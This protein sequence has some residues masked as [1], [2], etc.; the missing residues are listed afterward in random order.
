MSDTEKAAFPFV[1]EYRHCVG[2]LHRFTGEPER[3]NVK[4]LG[5]QRTLLD[6]EQGSRGRE[7]R[8]GFGARHE[9]LIGRI[10]RSDVDRSWRAAVVGVEARHCVQEVAA[11]RQPYRPEVTYF[12]TCCIEASQLGRRAAVGG[13]A[14]DTCGGLGKKDRAVAM[15]DRCVGNGRG[16]NCAR[17]STG[18]GHLLESSLARREEPDEAAVRR[19]ERRLGSVGEWHRRE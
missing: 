8:P 16:G 13:H 14:E 17:R 15:P 12:P 19:P 7:R 1:L 6:I 4:G 5:Q 18:Q 9:S 10:D 11:V 3:S 2:D